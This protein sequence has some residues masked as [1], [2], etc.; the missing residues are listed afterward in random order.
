MAIGV[1]LSGPRG[2]SGGATCISRAWVRNPE[3]LDMPTTSDGDDVIYIL[4]QVYGDD[5]PNFMSVY[6]TTSSG[7]YTVDLYNDGTTVT[8]NSSAAQADFDL[9]YS[10]GTGEVSEFGYKQVIT[11]ITAATGNLAGFDMYRIHGS[12]NAGFLQPTLSVKITSQTI[13]NLANAFRGAT[14][15]SFHRS[16]EEFEFFGT[17]NVTTFNSAFFNCT[18]LS[19]VKGNFE[20]VTNIGQ[21]FAYAGYIDISELQFATSGITTSNQLFKNGFIRKITGTA[22]AALFKGVRYPLS[23]MEN[24][25]NLVTF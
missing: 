9:D 22:G 15:K 10:K 14:A 19:K 8:N 5:R 18:E 16:L 12:A 25:A 1:G 4:S 6:A 11:K 21:M 2:G 17:C 23:I 20:D 7:N 3:W 24:A 13:A